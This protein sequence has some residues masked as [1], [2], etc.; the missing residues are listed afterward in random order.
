MAV[1]WQFHGVPGEVKVVP[2]QFHGSSM[3][4]HERSREF[5]ERSRAFFSR[6]TNRLTMSGLVNSKFHDF[7]SLC[8]VFKIAVQFEA[9]LACARVFAWFE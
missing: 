9:E 7:A 6:K 8:S 3:E 4:F 1:P 2:W 5:Q